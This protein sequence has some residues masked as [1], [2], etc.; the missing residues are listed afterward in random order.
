MRN[1]DY[2]SLYQQVVENEVDPKKRRGTYDKKTQD[3]RTKDACENNTA[4]RM[5]GKL[6]KK[7]IG[8][9]KKCA[10]PVEPPNLMKVEDEDFQSKCQSLI[11]EGFCEDMEDV[12]RLYDLIG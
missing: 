6:A 12:Y 8:T 5:S 9:G 11:E 3:E 7:G 2:R 1:I 10:S 4:R